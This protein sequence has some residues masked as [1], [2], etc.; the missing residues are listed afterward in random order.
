MPI[1]GDLFSMCLVIVAA[2]F[3]VFDLS[4]EINQKSKE[5]K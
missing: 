1:T 5:E 2:F 3:I 4:L